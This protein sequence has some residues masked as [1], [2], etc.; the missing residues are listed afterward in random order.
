MW[1]PLSYPPLETTVTA[2]TTSNIEELRARNL[3]HSPLLRLPYEIVVHILLLVMG[4]GKRTPTWVAILPTCHCLCQLILSTPALWGR[5]YCMPPE[6]IFKRFEMAAWSPTEIYVHAH[7]SKDLKVIG[8]ALDR[9]RCA[10]QL[11]RDRIHTLEFHGITD[12]WPHFSW[13]FDQPLPNLKHLSVSACMESGIAIPLT[14]FI[15]GRHLETLSVDDVEIP[16]SLCCFDNLRNLRVCFSELGDVRPQTLCQLIALLNSSPRLETFSFVHPTVPLRNDGQ[17][18]G[19]ATLSH[20]SSLRLEVPA[21]EVTSILD[22]LS[23]PVIDTLTLKPSKLVP[24]DI[25]LF[26]RN[27]LLANR[28]FKGTPNFPHH[29]KSAIRMGGFELEGSQIDDWKEICPTMH[30]MVLLSA[31]ELEIIKDQLDEG[32][33]REFAR[34]RPEVRSIVSSYGPENWA[35]SKGLWCALLP[36]RSRHPTTLFPKLGSVTL[37]AEHLSTIPSM[38]LRCLRMRSEAGF[39]LKY[40]VVQDT[41]GKIPRVGR[42]PEEFG[43]LADVFVYCEAPKYLSE[44]DRRTVI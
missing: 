17:R 41:S 35:L 32:H 38:A 22:H 44:V 12:M 20:L 29:T 6:N 28:L 8:A 4:D 25:P 43:S 23:L 10:R 16:A 31:T 42:Q 24:A 11:H 37:K 14:D 33:W 2:P 1:G 18:R 27:D 3:I 7:F 26:F 21:S 34:R 19:V 5:I 36:D 30:K 15:V 13:I 9:V 40:L 39:K